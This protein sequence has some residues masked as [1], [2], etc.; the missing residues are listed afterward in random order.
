MCGIAGMY[1]FSESKIIDFS[2]ISQKFRQILNKRGPD[3]N[4]DYKTNKLL[5]THNRLSVIDVS[6]K[7]NQ[8]ITSP[9]GS[10]TIILNG[11]I[12]NFKTLR[13]E[14][15]KKGLVFLSES[16]T[17]VVLHLY[18]QEGYNFLNRLN[19]FFALAIYDSRKEELILGRDRFGIKPLLYTYDNETFVFASEMKGIL[20]AL[21]PQEIDHA[22]LKMYLRLT[23]IPPPYTIFKNIQKLMPGSYLIVSDKGVERRSYFTLTPEIYRFGHSIT[24]E[25]ACKEIHK[26]MDNAVKEQ[27]ISDVPLGCFLSGGIDSSII[28]A[29]AA[30]NI[31][32]LKTFSIGFPDEP[33][34]DETIYAETIAKAYNTE[35]HSIML[36]NDNIFDAI[37][38]MLDNIDEPFADSSALAVYIL[39]RE[40]R[41]YI[42]VALSGDG[43]DEI[44]GG[45][46]RH[47]AEYRIRQK[48]FRDILLKQTEF[49]WKT[50]PVFGA[51]KYNDYVRK[52]RKYI[53]V[54]KLPPDERYRT[55]S[56]FNDASVVENLIISCCSDN[57]FHKRWKKIASEIK[58]N[59]QDIE[60]VM[61]S[62]ISLV[63]AGDML[64]KVDM[65]SM[66][67]SL[68]IRPPFLDNR[69]VDFAFS[70]PTKYKI[71]GL[72]NKKILRDAF[73]EELPPHIRKRF[74]HGFEVPLYNWFK[75][76]KNSTIDSYFLSYDYLKQQKLF[77]YD[78][79]SKQI[80][81]ASKNGYNN[82]QSFI[83]SLLVFQ[84]WYNKYNIH[85]KKDWL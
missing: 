62:D 67:H 35:H 78:V 26:L 13:K 28:T 48:L 2:H 64:P 21:E 12:F 49:I 70:I 82:L 72:T 65:M 40:A 43:A 8:P 39:S 16:D 68:E 79:I 42:T 75:A 52:L 61:L 1:L 77:R 50:L 7:A 33:Y 83:W 59:S 32:S 22:S 29:L 15:E 45:Y 53:S 63:L 17:E 20:E 10:C 66:A 38:D 51:G 3:T 55:L 25:S 84:H 57:E 24:Y 54:M 4:G 9:D 56:S 31:K 23:Y 74:K 11:E 47:V 37:E 46:N 5:L 34:Y 80:N 19:G 76:K 41:K 6:E 44:F 60:D 30:K 18:M 73:S 14:L 58:Q 69:V 27:L 85:I 81:F 36:K 71:S